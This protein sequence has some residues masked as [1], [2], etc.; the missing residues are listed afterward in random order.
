MLA[1]KMERTEILRKLAKLTGNKEQ[2]KVTTTAV[3]IRAGIT[4]EQILF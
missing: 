3:S 1:V 4:K 2:E